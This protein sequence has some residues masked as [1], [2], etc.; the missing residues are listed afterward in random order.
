MSSISLL[1]A[2]SAAT[3]CPAQTAQ[4]EA[5][6]DA[7]ERLYVDETTAMRIAAGLRDAAREGRYADLCTEPDAFVDALNRQL[8]TEDPHFHVE[9]HKD[10]PGDD[11]LTQWRADARRTGAGVREV[12]VLEGNIGYLRLASF[13]DWAQAGPQLTAAFTLVGHTDA[14]I[15]DLRRNGGGAPDTAEQLVRGF[16]GDGVPQVQSIRRRSG[17]LPD[18]LPRDGLPHY[19][20]PLAILVDR[21]T[22]SAAEFV[23]YSLQALGRATIVGSSTGG[24]AH[25]IGD[26]LPLDGGLLISIPDAA[27][28]NDITGGNWER[29][30]VSPDLPGGDDPLFVARR[31]LSDMLGDA[32]R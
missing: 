3:A 11:W 16:V 20:Q 30:G 7:V 5:A 1:I 15:L 25:M 2:L 23:A 29:R 12:S 24:A 9:S 32:A 22:G 28:V 17:T 18:P 10:V 14:L 21:R 8:D 19:D 31:R 26:P 13:H 6:A 4:L 27:P